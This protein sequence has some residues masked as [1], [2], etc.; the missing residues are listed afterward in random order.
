MTFCFDFLSLLLWAFTGRA[1]KSGDRE[2]TQEELTQESHTQRNS[3]TE[4]FLQTLHKDY[5]QGRGR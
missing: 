1:E 2:G 3:T 4:C 5:S